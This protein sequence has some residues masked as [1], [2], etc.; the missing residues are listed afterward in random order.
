MLI[1]HGLGRACQYACWW[2]AGKGHAPALETFMFTGPDQGLIFSAAGEAAR[3]GAVQAWHASPQHYTARGVETRVRTYVQLCTC[4]MHP[5]HAVRRRSCRYIASL[6]VRAA[7]G[8]R[9]YLTG[10]GPAYE[11]LGKSASI[12]PM[13]AAS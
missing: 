4:S 8:I 11:L 3:A 9:S 7:R 10:N 13:I 6:P 5:I 12:R 2:L 1:L